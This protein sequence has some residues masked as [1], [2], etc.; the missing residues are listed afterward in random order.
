[1]NESSDTKRHPHDV[2]II[3]LAADVELAIADLAESDALVESDCVLV[4]RENA[5]QKAPGA[6]RSGMGDGSG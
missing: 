3:I 4:L 6:G 2:V 1:M 5:K